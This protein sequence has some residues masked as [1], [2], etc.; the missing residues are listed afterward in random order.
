M[1]QQAF[2]HARRREVIGG[3]DVAH[4]DGHG[5]GRL[6]MVDGEA[7]DQQLRVREH[8]LADPGRRQIG[9]H[10]F[11]VGQFFQFGDGARTVDQRMVGQHH[12]LGLAGRA[13]G[14]EH[15]GG[16]L[17]LHRGDGGVQK[18][19]VPGR[20]FVAQRFQLFIRHQH[21]VGVVA[22]AARIVEHHAPE[23]GA[24]FADLQH[25]VDL[26]LVLDHGD[27]DLGVL[28]HVDHFLGHGVLVERHRDRAQRLR[29]H[30]GHVQARPVL[31]DHGHVH[32]GLD[33]QGGQAI[34]DAPYVLGHFRPRN[35]LPDP[36]IFFAYR[37]PRPAHLGMR[38]QQRRKS[39]RRRRHPGGCGRCMCHVVSSG[40]GAT[41][42]G[43]AGRR[44]RWALDQLVLDLRQD[45]RYKVG[46]LPTVTIATF[47]DLLGY[48]R[49]S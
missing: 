27:A 22:Q 40:L 34:G 48:S 37:G 31:A 33:A 32:A 5:V 42:R 35:G 19:G 44:W 10:V 46:L 7:G 13:R 28:Q 26:F 9:Q 14:V 38:E 24:L 47:K 16:V 2:E 4:V 49:C 3:A 45:L 36:Q 29:G 43:R 21:V 23:R 11:L 20:V 25:L 17:R 15:G 18:A 8:V 39:I 1:G 41:G 6:G 12:A 30:H